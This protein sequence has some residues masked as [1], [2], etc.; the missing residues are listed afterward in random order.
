MS[1]ADIFMQMV[2][3]LFSLTVHEMAH[4]WTAD[5]FGDPTARLL[6]RISLNPIVHTDPIGTILFPLV[7]MVS[8]APLLGWAKPVP[9]NLRYLRHPRRDYMLVAAAGPASNLA[10]A[11]FAALLL[12][13]VPVSPQTLGESNVSVPVAKFLGKLITLNVL[14][15][16]FNMIP[17]PPLDGGNVLAGLLPVSLADLFNRIRPYGFLLLYAL[18]LSGAFYYI[19]APPYNFILSWLPTR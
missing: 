10:L 6:G 11:L 15:A 7:A 18:V 2:V 19:V 4:A 12:V 1:L 14:L 3:L 8:G 5:Q 9:V 17:I 13:L 16:V